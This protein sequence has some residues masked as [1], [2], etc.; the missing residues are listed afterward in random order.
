VLPQSPLSYEG[1][2]I[3]IRWSVRLRVFFD[4]EQIT[5]DHFFR[6]GETLEPLLDQ[7]TS[8]TESLE[9]SDEEPGRE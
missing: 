3:Q 7:E 8:E 5:K 2:M 1:R 4:G 6:L 9:L